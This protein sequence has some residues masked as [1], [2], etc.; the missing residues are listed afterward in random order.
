MI[1]DRDIPYTPLTCFGDLRYDMRHLD[2]SRQFD[3]VRGFRA[4]IDRPPLS[5]YTCPEEIYNDKI[6][7]VPNDSLRKGTIKYYV[8]R[9]S[10]PYFEPVFDKCGEYDRVVFVDPMDAV[11]FYYP[12]K[13][14]AFYCNQYMADTNSFREE[15]MASQMSGMNINKFMAI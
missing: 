7:G 5:G 3:A 12:Y 15:L 6:V 4:R 11:K 14:K 2:D 13:S 1:P 10:Q 8:N 9:I